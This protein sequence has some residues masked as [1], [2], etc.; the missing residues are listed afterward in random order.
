MGFNVDWRNAVNGTRRNHEAKPDL[1][2]TLRASHQPVDKGY[3]TLVIQSSMG[4]N[5]SDGVMQLELTWN[6]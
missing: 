3:C 5:L 4:N 2:R 1:E 6:L